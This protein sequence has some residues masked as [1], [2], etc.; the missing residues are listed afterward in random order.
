M[1]FTLPAV[2]RLLAAFVVTCSTPVISLNH[3]LTFDQPENSFA[4]HNWGKYRGNPSSKVIPSPGPVSYFVTPVPFLHVS[5]CFSGLSELAVTSLFRSPNY[6]SWYP[7]MNRL[8]THW[9][10][11]DLLGNVIDIAI[12]T[13][14]NWAHRAVNVI[15]FY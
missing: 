4:L 7:F 11:D 12:S 1:D 2:T 13:S 3:V 15:A 8:V 9:S 6:A 14:V 5:D 10:T